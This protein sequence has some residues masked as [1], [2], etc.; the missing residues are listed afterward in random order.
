[1]LTLF[2]FIDNYILF[3]KTIFRATSILQKFNE[4]SIHY[5]L[6]QCSQ[7]LHTVYS[8]LR[9]S[10][11]ISLKFEIHTLYILHN[12]CYTNGFILEKLF[13]LNLLNF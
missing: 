10:V 2:T 12:L 9:M 3:P 1:M 13:F 6:K 7:K 5:Q 11:T 4:V 8:D